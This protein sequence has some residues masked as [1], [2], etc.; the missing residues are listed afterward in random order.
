LASASLVSNGSVFPARAAGSHPH[1]SRP[2]DV[3]G[4]LWCVSYRLVCHA[5]RLIVTRSAFGASVL[6]YLSNSA[7]LS[8][9]HPFPPPTAAVSR[10][11]PRPVLVPFSAVRR[12]S[13]RQAA[14]RCASGTNLCIVAPPRVSSSIESSEPAVVS[15]WR[16]AGT[17]SSLTFS[18]ALPKPPFVRRICCDRFTLFRTQRSVSFGTVCAIRTSRLT[19]LHSLRAGSPSLTCRPVWSPSSPHTTGASLR[20]PHK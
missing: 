19:V 16:R 1:H 14:V 9:L 2:R 13:D 4:R 18:W 17:G 3:C 10:S 15:S 12:E 7:P 11:R 6:T 5:L 20:S 8:A